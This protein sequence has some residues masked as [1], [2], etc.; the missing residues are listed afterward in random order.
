MMHHVSSKTTVYA[1]PYRLNEMPPDC[2]VA[3]C[4]AGGGLIWFQLALNAL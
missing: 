3:T 1:Q 4:I 2:N